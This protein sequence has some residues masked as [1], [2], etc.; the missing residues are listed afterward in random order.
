MNVEVLG[1]DICYGSAMA[2]VF[3][4]QQRAAARLSQNFKRPSFMRTPKYAGNFG[5]D[6]LMDGWLG[7]I[8]KG[9]LKVGKTVVKAVKSPSGKVVGAAALTAVAGRMTPT[10]KAALAA[11]QSAAGMDP[12]VIAAGG[13]TDLLYPYKQ[14]DP[15]SKNMPLILGGIA[16][17]GI[18]AVMMMKK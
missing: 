18:F 16:L 9:I 3:G 17:V 6:E 10:N 4:K 8:G 5:D 1:D 15:L 11:A 2:S 12:Q 14:Q 7:S 13:V